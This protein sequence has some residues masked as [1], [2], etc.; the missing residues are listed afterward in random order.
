[1]SQPFDRKAILA[2][3][4]TPDLGL[5]EFWIGNPWLFT[6]AKRNLSAYERNRVFLNAGAGQ[7]LDISYLSGAD[8]DGDGRT[9]V[10]TDVDR[11][12]RQDL[13]V[14]QVSGGPVLL[15]ENHLS[16]GHY[17]TVSLR[18][19]TSNRLGVGAEITAEVGKRKLVRELYPTCSFLSQ[20]PYEV[21]FGLGDATEIDRLAVRWPSGKVD[22]FRHVPVDRHVRLTEGSGQWREVA[23]K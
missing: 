1:M 16:A 5:G 19:T 4:G 3:P 6:P 14:R 12:G 10:P 13:F 9:A 22:T 17:L 23:A 21:H 11:D 7:F 2:A 15:F 18:G 8:S 20:Q